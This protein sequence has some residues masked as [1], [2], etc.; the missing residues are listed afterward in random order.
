VT[1]QHNVLPRLLGSEIR[2]K[3]QE[4]KNP[5]DA[6][7][8][9]I[10]NRLRRLL[11]NVAINMLRLLACAQDQLLGILEIL[12]FKLLVEDLPERLQVNVSARLGR[13]RQFSALSIS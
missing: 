9:V 3:R 7:L 8:K 11:G 6:R 5:V 2:V 4:R 1:E 12:G 13:V 10:G